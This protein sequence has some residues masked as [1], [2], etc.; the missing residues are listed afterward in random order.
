MESPNV[1]VLNRSQRLQPGAAAPPRRAATPAAL[2][3]HRRTGESGARWANPHRLCGSGVGRR[4]ETGRV[5][6]SPGR[7][8]AC[9]DPKDG[10]QGGAE[11][12]RSDFRT[13]TAEM[14]LGYRTLCLP[15][16]RK[17]PAR[18]SVTVHSDDRQRDEGDELRYRVSRANLVRLTRV[19]K[20]NSSIISASFAANPAIHVG[21]EIC[22]QNE[23]R[24]SRRRREVAR[25]MQTWRLLRVRP[26]AP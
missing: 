24:S 13:G 20:S 9:A 26:S 17:R 23:S 7:A 19:S 5:T 12:S 16:T 2:S 15:S 25:G 21:G 22:V 10:R 3:G 11:I 1:L 14:A 8:W 4:R 6:D 18:S